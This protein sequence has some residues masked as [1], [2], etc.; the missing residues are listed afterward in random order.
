VRASPDGYTLLLV[1][2]TNTYNATLYD[3]LSFNFIRDIVPIA[4]LDRSPFVMVVNPS[5]P[6]KTVPEFIA[7]AKANSGRINMGSSGIGT[8]GHVAGELFKAMAGVDMLHVPYRGR[9]FSPTT[10]CAHAWLQSAWWCAARQRRSSEHS[11]RTNTIGGAPFARP[12]AFRSSS[13]IRA[14]SP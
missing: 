8:P 3:N 13:G 12:P 9:I 1:T 6:A 7:Y 11:W 10:E 4:S 2:T 14:L 5:F